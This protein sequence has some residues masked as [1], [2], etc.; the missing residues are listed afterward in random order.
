MKKIITVI[1]LMTITGM[2]QAQTPGK[3]TNEQYIDLWSINGKG[4]PC[5]K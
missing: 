3:P 1:M 5:N 4:Y 2:C